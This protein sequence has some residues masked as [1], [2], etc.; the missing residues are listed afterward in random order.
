M[1]HQS[2]ESPDSPQHITLPFED[3]TDEESADLFFSFDITALA[4]LWEHQ[5]AGGSNLSLTRIQR[6]EDTNETQKAGTILALFFWDLARTPITYGYLVLAFLIIVLATN[7]GDIQE[8]M[9][10]TLT[11]MIAP[12]IEAPKPPPPPKPEVTK[13]TPKPK[14]VKKVPPKIKPKKPELKIDKPKPL[15]R[16]I[17]PKEKPKIKK[18]EPEPIQPKKLDKLN[19][20]RNRKID[21]PKLEK[22]N[23]VK[24]KSL[25]SGSMD[26][27]GIGKSRRVE[28]TSSLKQISTAKRQAAPDAS[29]QGFKIQA[30]SQ[31]DAP[32]DLPAS[33]AATAP[34]R[35]RPKADY[36]APS[37]S[38]IGTRPPAPDREEI[39]EAEPAELQ[40][41]VPKREE[42][43]EAVVVDEIIIIP[44]KEDAVNYRFDEHFSGSWQKIDNIGPLAHLNAKC[45]RV[46]TGRVIR[47]RNFI[48]RCSNNQITD[49]WKQIQK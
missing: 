1:D 46:Q 23:T 13:E 19:T 40:I 47:Y 5:H 34:K 29:A 4:F 7:I 39:I 8:K 36:K 15:K 43:E 3:F 30:R 27:L 37:L 44:E 14:P 28:S 6:R 42:I 24:R 32:A 12:E 25:D 18:R 10:D 35:Q 11:S 9:R 49:A 16:E 33:F 20:V 31:S 21:E 2:P 22:L 48:F 38:A 45:Y 17:P 26:K 41:A